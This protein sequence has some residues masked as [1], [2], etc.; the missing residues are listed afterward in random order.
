MEAD[1]VL[2][3]HVGVCR[4]VVVEQFVVLPVADTGNVVGERIEP[5]IDDLLFIERHRNAPGLVGARDAKVPQLAANHV[6]DFITAKVRQHGFG[7]L[8]VEGE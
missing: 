5:N 8:V 4:P 1:D 7:V 3:N 6:Y 2:P